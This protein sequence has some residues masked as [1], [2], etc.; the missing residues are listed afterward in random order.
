MLLTVEYLDGKIE[1]FTQRCLFR[2]DSV[3]A[4]YRLLD[5]RGDE[6]T[7]PHCVVRKTT[8]SKKGGEQ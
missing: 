2:S 6:I 4:L 1:Q 7:I 8:L 5:E 3:A